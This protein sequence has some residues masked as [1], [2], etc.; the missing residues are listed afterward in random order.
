MIGRT[1]TYFL[2]LNGVTSILILF[3]S[4][5]IHKYMFRIRRGSSNRY[6]LSH[7]TCFSGCISRRPPNNQLISGYYKN[8]KRLSMYDFYLMVESCRVELRAEASGLQPPYPVP[9]LKLSILPAASRRLLFDPYDLAVMRLR[10][11]NTF[12]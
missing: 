9:G 8:F 1:R 6:M 11:P 4:L 2:H 7:V 5:L 12:V 10:G 3:N